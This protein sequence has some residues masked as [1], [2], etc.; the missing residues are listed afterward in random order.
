MFDDEEDR[1]RDN[2]SDAHGLLMDNNLDNQ[3]TM[4]QLL[5]LENTGHKPLLLNIDFQDIRSH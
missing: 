4:Y 5:Q 1:L 3:S 2:G